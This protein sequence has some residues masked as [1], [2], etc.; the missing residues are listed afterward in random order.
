MNVHWHLRDGVLGLLDDQDAFAVPTA[1]EIFRVR[2]GET[3]RIDGFPSIDD[4]PENVRAL[5][6]DRYPCDLRVRIQAPEMGREKLRARVLLLHRNGQAELEPPQNALYGHVVIGNEWHA[7]IPHQVDE[8]Q[9]LAKAAGGGLFSGLTLRQYLALRVEALD[10]DILDNRLDVDGSLAEVSDLPNAPLP[11]GFTAVLY[12]YQAAG[13]EWLSRLSAQEV[14][15]ILADEMG[16]GKTV[17]IIARLAARAEETTTPSLVIGTASILENWRRELARFAPGLSVLVH[18]GSSRTGRPSELRGYNVIV[19]SYDTVVRDIVLLSQF[20]WDVIV[21]DEAQFL[22]NPD[23][24]RA[25]CARQLR[26]RTLIASTGT[27]VENS[28]RDLWSLIDLSVPGLLPDR[29]TFRAH[30]PDEPS[31]AE[32]LAEITSPVVLRR[33]VSDVAADLPPRIDIPTPLV[34]SLGEAAAYEALRQ[35]AVG[36]GRG[37]SLGALMKLRQYCAHP[38]L[39]IDGRQDLE[40]SSVKYARLLEVLQEIF[41]S[42][43]KALVFAGFQQMI[44]LLLRDITRRFS[45]YGQAIDGRTAIEARQPI[46]DAFSAAEG[47]A[48]LVLN[49]RAAGAGL[50][51]AAANHVIHYTPEWNPAVEDQA[52]ARSHRRGQTRPVTIHRMFYV[53]SVEEVMNE[54]MTRKRVLID[55][56]VPDSRDDAQDARDLVLALQRSPLSSSAKRSDP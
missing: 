31:A 55:K 50:N 47:G 41:E 7:I 45:V 54:R 18:H 29:Q 39:V 3:D 16:L 22:K 6:F 38:N 25:G 30:F 44:D 4:A 51:I 26:G 11:I 32:M 2:F 5:S 9:L 34:F 15:G 46:I 33:R 1:D 56:A 27:P 36:P 48:V 17:Q 14:G 49:P 53:D 43:E 12:P 24:Q 42:G 10:V 52:S 35:S 37:A 23:T 8:L 28:L 13:V 20:E 21:A 19:L 40:I